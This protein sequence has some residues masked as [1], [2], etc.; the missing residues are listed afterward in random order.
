MISISSFYTDVNVGTNKLIYISISNNNYQLIYYSDYQLYTTA[1]NQLISTI[2]INF[3]TL[4]NNKKPW[5]FYS[6]EKW[7]SSTN[8]L[9]E[10]TGTGRNATTS[11]V[12]Q[13]YSSDNGAVS[14][15]TYLTGLS[16]STI[17]FPA[18]SIPAQFTICSLTRY[19]GSQRGRILQGNNGI[20]FLHGHWMG[21]RGMVYYEGWKSSQT[22]SIGISTDWLNCCGTNNGSVSI[23][24]NILFNGIAA[25]VVNSVN[26]FVE[27][28]HFSAE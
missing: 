2:I 12:I 24:N 16:T 28:F 11:G 7:N 27:E 3:S 18:G 9:T 25:G 10:L 5:G 13:V 23:S 22:D 19:N 17:T 4:I 14:S 1:I 20:N 8:I 6:A 21:R 26:I 15:I